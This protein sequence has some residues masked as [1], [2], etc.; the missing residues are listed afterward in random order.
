VVCT[1]ALTKHYILNKE[2]FTKMEIQMKKINL[3]LK[4]VGIL[5][6]VF[7][8][9]TS[10]VNA[11]PYDLEII[12]VDEVGEN[13]RIKY[14]YPNIKYKV[15]IAAFGGTSP[16][17]WK[18]LKSP[19]GME[20][21]NS[22]GEIIWKNPTMEESGSTIQVEVTD[23]EGLSDKES[24]NITVTDSTNRFI[25]VDSNSYVGG[26]GSIE[27]P[28]Q[29]MDEFWAEDNSG[30]II[31]LR[32]GSHTYPKEKGSI[33]ERYTNRI[34]IKDN[35]PKSIIGFPGEEVLLNGESNGMAGYCFAPASINDAYFENII[36]TNNN[37]YALVWWGGKYGTV[38]NCTF[39]NIYT[40]SKHAN[41][42]YI[43]T[44][45][46]DPPTSNML[47][48]HNSF[49]RIQNSQN[50]D[51]F[52]SAVETYDVSN[53]TWQ[54]NEIS[55]NATY[56]FFFKSSND[57]V[58]IK[59]NRISQTSRG[60]VYI[61]GRG[62]SD[63]VISFNFF[64]NDEIAF[65]STRLTSDPDCINNIK[66]YRNTFTGAPTFRSLY[67]LS[68]KV[69]KKDFITWKNNVIQNNLK[70]IGTIPGSFNR[71]NIHYQR[72]SEIEYTRIS[73]EMSNDLRGTSGIVDNNGRLTP[74]FTKNYYGTHGWQTKKDEHK[75]IN[76]TKINKPNEFGIAKN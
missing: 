12:N 33:S 1:A 65:Y 23:S 58:S 62:L 31:Y 55:I 40:S 3:I 51:N 67:E 41:Q 11:S 63:G 70:N 15:V 10:S 7:F 35:N 69:Y 74:E 27:N 38:Y 73:N 17:E 5:V 64:D 59:H 47:L 25:F 24:F 14:A 26:N 71:N 9:L 22:T 52:M 28:Y 49:E 66:V 2:T 29:N 6:I 37:Y 54:Y 75:N 46:T 16:Y 48:S 45:A 61:Y 21:D 8:L 36:F 60:G 34:V 39:K 42:G 50:N 13:N 30:T 20:I 19:A 76:N 53:S 57:H 32:E 72:I 44:M 68:D 18:L 4:L 56:G 43:N